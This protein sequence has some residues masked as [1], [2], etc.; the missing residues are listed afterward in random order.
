MTTCEDI[1]EIRVQRRRRQNMFLQLKG[2]EFQSQCL[3]IPKKLINEEQVCKRCRHIRTIVYFLFLF[4]APTTSKTEYCI[5]CEQTFPRN[6]YQGHLRSLQH[7]TKSCMSIRKGVEII[8][9]AFKKR[10]VS[11]RISGEYS[12]I[13]Y[14]DFFNDVKQKV[15]NV[16]ECN[17]ARLK[18]LK[19]N[20]EVFG[21]Y[22]HQTQGL[23]DVKSFNT[24]Y[25]IMNDGVDIDVLYNDFVDIMKA[26]TSEFQERNSGEN[27]K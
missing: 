3:P 13:D 10:I 15:K 9:T 18:A 1:C 20:M 5:Q 25:R 17:I 12:H 14:D 2:L 24:A 27:N 16:I 11:Y 23:I 21:R 6:Q 26:K 22:I 4:I 7:K 8:N 19:V